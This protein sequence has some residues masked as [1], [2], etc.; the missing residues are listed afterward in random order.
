MNKSV[1]LSILLVASSCLVSCKPINSLLQIPGSIVKSVIG[2]LRMTDAPDQPAV[3]GDQVQEKMT[4]PSA[5]E[6]PT[7][8]E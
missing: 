2:P 6:A 7:V 5:S 8:A 4:A 1:I 3:N